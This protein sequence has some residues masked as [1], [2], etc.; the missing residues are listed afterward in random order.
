MSPSNP[1]RIDMNG[2]ATDPVRIE[3]I[4]ELASAVAEEIIAL[5]GEETSVDINTSGTH[6]E[7]PA[8]WEDLR[9]P[10]Q[11]INPAGAAAPPSVDTVLTSLPGT[12]IFSGSAE[13]VISGVAQMPHGWKEGT[14]IHPHIHWSKI[15]ADAEGL[16]VGWEF[17]YRTS[18]KG[19]L[20]SAWSEYSAHTL[21]LGDNTSAEKHN[22]S[23]FPAIVMTGL[24][25]SC[26][27][28][29]VIRRKGNTDAYNEATRLLE[30]D[31]HYQ[32]DTLGSTQ[33]AVK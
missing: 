5:L 32:I 2:G 18:E 28:A 6:V 3:N 12:L 4:A 27:V 31:I 11:A 10:A 20:W 14:D 26:M 13:N 30:F 8:R 19:A 33:E 9:F 17:K 1:V 24:K 21:E 16:A 25:V 7:T 22:L 15:V 23:E 29:W